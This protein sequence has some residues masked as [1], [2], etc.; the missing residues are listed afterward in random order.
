MADRSGELP[1]ST[2]V[3]TVTI[4]MLQALISSGLLVNFKFSFFN[5]S[6]LSISFVLSYPACNSLTLFL[7]ISKPV[8]SCLAENATATGRPTYPRPIIAILL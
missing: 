1:S 7:L 3:G 8:T 4:K 5:N 2:G 6:C